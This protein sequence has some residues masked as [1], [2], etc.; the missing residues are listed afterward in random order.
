MGDRAGLEALA[1]EQAE[2]ATRADSPG[3]HVRLAEL[4]LSNNPPTDAQH[5]EAHRLIR[6]AIEE[7]GQ[8]AVDYPDDID[9]RL[10]AATGFVELIEV[11]GAT[12]G[13]AN[14]VDEA[15]LRLSAELSQITLKAKRLAAPAASV[16]ALYPIALM[17][18]RLRDEA[19]YRATCK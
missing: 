12:E 19:G 8:V 5:V 3:Y 2:Q 7:Y 15:K 6:R 17:Q 4:L 13:F 18:L 11:C 10:N 1:K 9:R 16:D 14:Q